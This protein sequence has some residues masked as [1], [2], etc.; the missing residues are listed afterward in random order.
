MVLFWI[1]IINGHWPNSDHS[2]QH[3]ILN[4]T[5]T[6]THT[7]SVSQ[8][9]RISLESAALKISL[10]FIF[11]QSLSIISALVFPSFSHP[12]FSRLSRSMYVAALVVCLPEESYL[13]LFANNA[14]S[15]KAAHFS[16]GP[17]EAGLSL[18]QT[19]LRRNLSI[20]TPPWQAHAHAARNLKAE[21][22]MFTKCTTRH[23]TQ[24]SGLQTKIKFLS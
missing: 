24:P 23:L 11:A 9:N 4:E 17:S 14:T 21:V 15:L 13:S 8:T 5:H 16:E 6:H 12:P 10:S 1:F 3:S 22:Q 19:A 2:F 18:R 20:T 7:L